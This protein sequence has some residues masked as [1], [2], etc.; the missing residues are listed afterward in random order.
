MYYVY[1]G[2]GVCGRKVA[3]LSVVFELKRVLVP[4]AAGYGRFRSCTM[5]EVIPSG[6]WI[7]KCWNIHRRGNEDMAWDGLLLLLATTNV[8]TS[9]APRT[10]VIPIP[11]SFTV[12]FDRVKFTIILWKNLIYNQNLH[13]RIQ[14]FI[15]SLNWNGLEISH[16][17][18]RFRSFTLGFYEF[19]LWFAASFVSLQ[20]VCV[21]V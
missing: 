4:D 21:F 14:Q 16:G 13:T 7:V 20:R 1:V 8:D 5:P 10:T 9:P 6:L 15:G 12:C 19:N 18:W 3:Q 11:F 17:C 2:V